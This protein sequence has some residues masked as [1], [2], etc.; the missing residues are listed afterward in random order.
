MSKLRAII[1][2]I[3]GRN[4]IN[5]RFYVKKKKKYLIFKKL[6]NFEERAYFISALQFL[7]AMSRGIVHVSLNR[8]ILYVN[9]RKS[10]AL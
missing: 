7:N 4:W 1:I 5:P 9:L 3:Q 8:I 10:V 2:E 6:I